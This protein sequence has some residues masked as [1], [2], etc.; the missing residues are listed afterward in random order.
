MA[1]VVAQNGFPL[2]LGA[3]IFSWGH[4]DGLLQ[5]SETAADRISKIYLAPT[6]P[7]RQC[8]PQVELQII[9]Q[10]GP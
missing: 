1:V 9:L 8:A 3:A 4:G 7:K 2:E 6:F 5:E 10:E